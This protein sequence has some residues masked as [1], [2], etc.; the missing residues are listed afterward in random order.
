MSSLSSAR[1]ALKH[2]F[3]SNHFL[4]EENADHIRMIRDELTACHQPAGDEENRLIAD[5]ALAQFKVFENDRLRH[6]RTVEEQSQAALIFERQTQ[7]DFEKRQA[8]WR[9]NPADSIALLAANRLGFAFLVRQWSELREILTSGHSTITLHQ[10]CEAAMMAGSRWRIEELN[11]LGRRIFGLFLAMHPLPDLQIDQWLKI[12]KT[13]CE[14]TDTA[15]AQEIYALAPS[16]DEARLELLEL[17]DE[18]L[19]ML[20]FDEPFVIR[21]HEIGKKGFMEKSCGLGLTDPVRTNEARLFMRYYT[22]DLNRADKLQRM[23]DSHKHDRLI[24]RHSRR[25]TS[26][27]NVAEEGVIG[28]GADAAPAA[29]EERRQTAEAAFETVPGETNVAMQSLFK[30]KNA[31]VFKKLMEQQLPDQ[32]AGVASVAV[33]MQNRMNQPNAS[34]EGLLDEVDWSDPVSLTSDDYEIMEKIADM[35]KS[36]GRD[37]LVRI[38]FGTEARFDAARRQLCRQPA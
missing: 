26:R 3:C 10:A 12:S 17:V 27:K 33:S 23:F 4:L 9:A 13:V 30:A 22:A 19:A 15:L 8:A 31:A 36:A 35:A 20:Q 2:G 25:R 1:N 37:N 38:Y 24:G 32:T 5:L 21:N 11:L 34:V 18:Q 16:A 7:A 14:V 6:K 28:Q 29:P